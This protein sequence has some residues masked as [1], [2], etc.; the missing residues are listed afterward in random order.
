MGHVAIGT[1]G[2]VAVARLEPRRVMLLHDVAVGARLGI[3]REVRR[4]LCVDKGECPKPGGETEGDGN[5]ERKRACGH[6][7]R[8]D[9]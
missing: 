7:A 1:L 8:T 9:T 3:G 6:A 5:A 2:N 4:A